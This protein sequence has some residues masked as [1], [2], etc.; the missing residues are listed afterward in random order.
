MSLLN[1]KLN[2]GASN[3]PL[4]DKRAKYIL[5][6]LKQNIDLSKVTTAEWTADMIQARQEYFFEVAMRRWP[7]KDKTKKDITLDLKDNLWKK[8]IEEKDQNLERDNC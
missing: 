2:I 4:E 8:K 6:D 5:S 3:L 7:I 1:S